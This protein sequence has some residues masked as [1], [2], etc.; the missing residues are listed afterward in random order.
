MSIEESV[1]FNVNNS[2]SNNQLHQ[3]YETFEL[4]YLFYDESQYTSILQQKVIFII[5]LF[6]D[7]FNVNITDS[8]SNDSIYLIS[9]PT[10]RFRQRCRIQLINIENQLKFCIWNKENE[11]SKNI[12]IIESFPI[13]SQEINDLMPLILEFCNQ[14]HHINTIGNNL[15]VINFFTSLS[16]RVILSFIYSEPMIPQETWITLSNQL[17]AFLLVKIPYIKEINIIGRSKGIKYVVGNEYI[18]EE[19]P[20]TIKNNPTTLMLK[21]MDGGFASPNANVNAKAL[22]WICQ[23]IENMICNISSPVYLLEMFCGNGN[24][25]MALASILDYIIAVELN[26]ILCQAAND[27]IEMNNITNVEIIQANSFQFSNQVL[28]MKQYTNK[29]GQQYVYLLTI[30]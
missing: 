4:P 11:L 16:H 8:I 26:P 13:A 17:I 18:W 3:H 24:H 15:T 14:S 6:Q 25:T 28:K 9:S 19:L 29:F 30:I 7:L 1:A 21:Q 20:V 27:N 23:T 12:D 2:S 22:T 5:N 10:R